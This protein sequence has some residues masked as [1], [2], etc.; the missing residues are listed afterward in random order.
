M[1]VVKTISF[2][3]ET[4]Q[5]L[6]KCIVEKKTEHTNVSSFVRA[7]VTEKLELINKQKPIKKG[8]K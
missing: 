4:F 3:L 6:E 2:D 5:T 8:A 1:T 7:A